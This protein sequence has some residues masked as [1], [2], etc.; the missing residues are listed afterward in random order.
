MSRAVLAH[1]TVGTRADAWCVV[2]VRMTETTATARRRSERSPTRF[3]VP[4]SV[5]R[6]AFDPR[7][8]DRLPGRAT[9]P[10]YA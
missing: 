3:G 2:K 9:G 8:R 10:A 1:V 7:D 5:L 4:A 6:P